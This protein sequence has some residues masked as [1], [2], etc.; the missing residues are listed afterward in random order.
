MQFDF[1][2]NCVESLIALCS[3]DILTMLYLPI[4]EYEI[5]SS[6]FYLQLLSSIFYSLQYMVLSPIRLNL[7]ISMLLFYFLGF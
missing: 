6:H 5:F 7:F 4:N 2:K 1:N 3:T